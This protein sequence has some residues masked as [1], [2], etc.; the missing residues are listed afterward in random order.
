[1]SSLANRKEIEDRERQTLAPYAALSAESRG[2][3][4]PQEEHELRTAYQR[5]RDRIIH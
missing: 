5:D 2:R 3:V 1:M 4:Y